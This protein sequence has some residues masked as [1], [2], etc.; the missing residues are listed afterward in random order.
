[1]SKVRSCLRLADCLLDRGPEISGIDGG[2][3]IEVALDRL[4]E[5]Q[6]LAG[7]DK[8]IREHPADVA[9]VLRMASLDLGQSLSVGI[10][11]EDRQL[12]ISTDENG[13]LFP[14]RERRNEVVRR[15]ELEVQ[16]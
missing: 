7:R 6:E 11:M 13:A 3:P 2:I 1:M 10:V 14:A 4:E 8:A 12:A 5:L 16:P 15:R 9:H